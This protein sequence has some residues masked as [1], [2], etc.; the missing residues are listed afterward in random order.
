VLGAFSLVPTFGCLWAWATK[1]A[2]RVCAPRYWE[3]L[4]LPEIRAWW[5]GKAYKF[6]K[7]SGLDCGC[8]QWGMEKMN[9]C[10]C[11]CVVF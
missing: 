11:T 8:K 2:S 10:F 6:L 5:K 3:C 4:P 9:G 1:F 7:E